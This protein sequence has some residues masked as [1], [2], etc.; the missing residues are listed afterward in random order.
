[1]RSKL[2]FMMFQDRVF[3]PEYLAAIALQ[4]G[5]IQDF[6]KVIRLYRESELDVK[7]F[8]KIIKEHNLSRRWN[9]FKKKYIPADKRI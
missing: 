2:P 6:E 1:M 9:E 7:Y 3:R 5:S 4:T 8:E